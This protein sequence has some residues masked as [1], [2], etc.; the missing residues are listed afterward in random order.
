MSTNDD[1]VSFV[2]AELSIPE[3][4]FV[5]ALVQDPEM[6]PPQAAEA[7]GMAGQGAELMRRPSVRTAVSRLLGSKNDRIEEIRQATI[8]ALYQLAFGWDPKNMMR[9]PDERPA[10]VLAEHLEKHLNVKRGELRALQA[11]DREAQ[12]PKFLAP[13]ELPPECRAAL[14]SMEF[15]DGQWKYTMVDRHV[16][17]MSLLKHFGDMDK[18][19]E[20][21]PLTQDDDKVT[22]VMINPDGTKT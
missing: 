9:P 3:R 10:S 14:K 1:T 2:L 5:L 16:V 12:P 18:V 15:K 13:D 7:A 22:I 6:R 19:K 17:L 8:Y 4:S 21:N 20:N 11:L